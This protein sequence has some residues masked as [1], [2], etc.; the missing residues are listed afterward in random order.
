MSGLGPY[1]PFICLKGIESSIRLLMRDRQEAITNLIFSRSSAPAACCP[2]CS[3][4]SVGRSSLFMCI[5][6]Q[7]LWSVARL[8]PHAH[9][10]LPCQPHPE[11]SQTAP[12]VLP[13]HARASSRMRVSGVTK[14]DDGGA[15]SRGAVEN[16][17]AE[18][19]CF[20]QATIGLISYGVGTIGLICRSVGAVGGQSLFT[21]LSQ[22]NLSLFLLSQ[23]CGKR[24]NRRSRDC[25][26]LP[27]GQLMASSAGSAGTGAWWDGAGQGE[28]SPP[29]DDDSLLDC[30]A[31]YVEALSACRG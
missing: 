21:L 14:H 6:H 27:L 31:S 19:G 22:D 29:P 1:R 17:H 18:E 13:R 12:S 8:C 4:D 24:R 7:P 15:S 9:R 26:S 30:L 10:A 23:V 28:Q 2:S 3:C 25:A 20:P 16:V 5:A 11:D